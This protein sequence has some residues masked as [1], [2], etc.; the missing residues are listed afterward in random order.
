MKSR[1]KK[2]VI[3]TTAL[4]MLFGVA[5]TSHASGYEKLQN[6]TAVSVSK[7]NI[8]EAQLSSAEVIECLNNV[9]FGKDI[10]FTELPV[11]DKS[12]YIKFDSVEEAENYIKQFIEERK[13]YEQTLKSGY[14]LEKR[15]GKLAKAKV[16]NGWKEG[17]VNWWGGGNT[18]LLS[19]TNAMIRHY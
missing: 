2:G 14:M 8:D 18:S 11:D 15:N 7:D 5:I 17:T 9:D 19:T 6:Q 16:K 4:S 12:E 1:Y 3:I 13:E 10:S